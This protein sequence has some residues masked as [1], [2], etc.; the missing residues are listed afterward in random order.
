LPTS[1]VIRDKITIRPDLN[2]QRSFVCIIKFY[3]VISARGR[4]SECWIQRFYF[5]QI[6][7]IDV[8]CIGTIFN[9]GGSPYP[10]DHIIGKIVSRI[11][12]NPLDLKV[13][14]VS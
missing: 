7:P 5:V 4:P 14:N 13:D 10:D 2:D 8:S 6:V 11:V 1:S 12:P 3:G 9:T